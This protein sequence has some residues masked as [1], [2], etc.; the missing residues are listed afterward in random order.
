MFQMNLEVELQ[1]LR[2]PCIKSGCSYIY[3]IWKA[4]LSHWFKL[5][6]SKIYIA[7]PF[8]DNGRIND[9]IKFALHPS[10]KGMLEKFIV[11]KKNDKN[12]L[13]VEKYRAELLS[14]ELKTRYPEIMERVYS[15]MEQPP[16]TFHCKFIAVI[17][18]N[19]VAEMLVTSANFQASHFECENMESI[20]YSTMSGTDF[21]AKFINPLFLQK[22][23][24]GEHIQ[25]QPTCAATTSVPPLIAS[26]S[27]TNLGLQN[28]TQRFNNRGSNSWR[29]SQRMPYNP[30]P[31]AGLYSNTRMGRG[32][33]N[34]AGQRLSVPGK[35]PPSRFVYRRKRPF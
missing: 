14:P 28:H 21:M 20:F 34:S 4:L 10:S 1:F 17:K 18:S 29:G 8:L 15:K 7:S 2:T 12:D 32:V 31:Q 19:G 22:L 11:R 30:T 3:K 26:T 13:E 25:Q 23:Q 27:P 35:A 33:F 24:K 5:E 16:Q 9:I 6:G